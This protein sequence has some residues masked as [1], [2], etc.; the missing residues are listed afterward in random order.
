MNQV[1]FMNIHY[2]LKMKIT[3]L[4][5]LVERKTPVAVLVDLLGHLTNL[6]LRELEPDN[7]EGVLKLCDFDVAISVPVNLQQEQTIRGVTNID[8][9]VKWFFFFRRFRFKT[10]PRIYID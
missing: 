8:I 10:L 5:K 3:Y 7:V 6:P 2:H 4:S 9:M 1:L